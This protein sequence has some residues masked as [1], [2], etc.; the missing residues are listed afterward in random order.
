MNPLAYLTISITAVFATYFLSH[1]NNLKVLGEKRV[2]EIRNASCDLIE[3][4]QKLYYANDTRYN[5]LHIP[6][7]GTVTNEVRLEILKQCE[8]YQAHVV[9]SAS[10]LRL[11]FK[12]DDKDYNNLELLIVKLIEGC[13]LKD[14]N[15]GMNIQNRNSA[16]NE[17]LDFLR[18]LL[19]RYW[20]EISESELNKALI[21]IKSKLHPQKAIS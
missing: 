8:H 4:C 9:S 11:L 2:T 1:R 20:N 17:L 6:P 13:D 10:K 21:Y 15:N 16:E 18:D 14:F 12:S 3:A 7:V 19:D 5:Q